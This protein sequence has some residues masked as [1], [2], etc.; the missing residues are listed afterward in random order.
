MIKEPP[1]PIVEIGDKF[2]ESITMLAY[3]AGGTGKTEFL[4]S[5]GEKGIILSCGE[6]QLTLKG[7]GFRRRHPKIPKIVYLR[8]EMDPTTGMFKRADAWDKFT[9]F[10]DWFVTQ[11]DFDTLG[12]DDASILGSY[13]RNKGMETNQELGIGAPIIKSRQMGFPVPEIADFGKEVGIWIWFLSTHLS[14]FKE[15]RKNIVI[16]AHERHIYSKGAIGAPAILTKI[17]PGFTGNVLPD[18]IQNYFDF[19]WKF[20]VAN[21]TVFRCKTISNENYVAKTRWSDVF[22]EEI[23]N[24]DFLK[25]LNTLKSGGKYMP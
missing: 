8:E 1:L 13:A 5:I 4:G 25:I 18:A 7:P 23:K 10:C 19:V 17:L 14:K 3:G 11:D 22:P 2:E 16:S 20:E 6:G 15:R 9:D 24:P 21:G 12:A